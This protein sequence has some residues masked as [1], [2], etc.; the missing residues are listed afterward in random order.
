LSGSPSTFEAWLHATEYK[1]SRHRKVLL[2]E[3][4][5]SRESVVPLLRKIARSHY[6]SPKTMAK[7]LANLGAPKT[8]SLLREALPRSKRA[9]SGD[10]GEILATEFVNAMLDFEVPIR[11]LQWKDGREMALRGDDLIG[12]AQDND[13]GEL[14]LLKGE[15]KSR[16]NLSVSVVKDAAQALNRNQGRPSRHAVLFVANRLRELGQ[17]DDAA[18]LENAVLE[19]FRR[20]NIQHL[21]FVF[22]GN[23]PDKNLTNYLKNYKRRKRK[24][25][26]IGLR[27]KD[28]GEFIRK[29]Y[30]EM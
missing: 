13:K 22:C 16:A 30:E 19:G 6:V 3:R 9:R 26:A 10:L 2:D 1:V 15:A 18:A 11:R 27:V 25:N 12:V 17:D 23:D 28:H 8:A 29:L 21:L 7:R 24:R 20:T 5:G 4:D 14:R